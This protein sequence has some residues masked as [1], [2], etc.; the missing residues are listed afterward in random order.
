GFHGFQAHMYRA[1]HW[2][3]RARQDAGHD[4]WLVIVRGK[5]HVAHAVIQGNR[6]AD[7]VSQ[8][9]C[10]FRAQHRFEQ[11]LE[12]LAF[13]QFQFAGSGISEMLEIIRYRTD[14]RITAMRISEGQGYCPGNRRMGAD[15]LHTVPAHVGGRLAH[16]KN[17][18]QH[19][20]HRT[21]S[22]ADNQIST[23]YGLRKAFPRIMAQTLHTQQHHHTQR[24]GHYHQSHRQTTI[25]RAAPGQYKQVPHTGTSSLSAWL[26]SFSATARSKW[27]TSLR[28]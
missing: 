27:E 14:H 26:M 12:D 1:V 2:R 9:L 25:P 13:L 18:I 22:C 15:L 16:A 28:S 21:G 5:S 19:Q 6:V 23:G 20:L 8:A 17:R 4:E 11:R 10:H 3:T 24:H 7:L